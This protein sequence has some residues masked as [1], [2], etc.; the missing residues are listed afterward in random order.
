[1]GHRLELD[2]DLGALLWKPLAGA[3]EEGHPRPAPVVDIGPDGDEG[4]RVRRLA[5]LGLIAVD[6][7]ALDRAF[8][9][10]A[11]HGDAFGVLGG[12]GAQRAQHLHLFVAH[13]IRVQ[14]AGRLHRHEAQQLQHMV[15]HHVPQ[16][17]VFVVIRPAVADADRLTDRDLH[18]VDG[19]IVPQRFEDGVAEAQGDQVLHRLLA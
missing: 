8:H 15:L 3:H 5:A 7:A 19:Q 13:R 9:I 14:V 4:L 6:G 16:R 18:M 2:D 12:D 10:L 17:A 1:M 11:A